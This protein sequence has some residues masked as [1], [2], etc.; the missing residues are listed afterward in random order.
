MGLSGIK[1]AVSNL[2]SL[3]VRGDL[4]LQVRRDTFTQ[5]MIESFSEAA[6]YD[7]GMRYYDG[8]G[9]VIITPA[10]QTPGERIAE[11]EQ[12]IRI[13]ESGGEK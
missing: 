13:L 8:W 2:R 11:L 3:G 4:A 1:T 9:Q 12:R 7:D 5:M 6:A 10:D